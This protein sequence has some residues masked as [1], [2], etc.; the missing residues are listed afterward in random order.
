MRLTFSN[1]EKI[2]LLLEIKRKADVAVNKTFLSSAVKI[3][4]YA[5]K[6]APWKDRTGRA[7]RTLMGRAEF[8]FMGEKK[9]SIIGCMH[10]SPKLE[11]RFG[12]KFSI[13]FPT[14]LENASDILNETAKAVGGIT[15]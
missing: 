12:G 15:L 8:D 13:L 6:N 4:D 14:I 5:K 9:L 10:Y 7:R 11:F 3:Q 1:F 2:N